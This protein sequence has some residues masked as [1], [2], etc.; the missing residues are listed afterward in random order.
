MKGDAYRAS[1]GGWGRVIIFV[2]SLLAGV[3][4]AFLRVIFP[5]HVL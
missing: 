5:S 2:N 1:L 3:W 4:L